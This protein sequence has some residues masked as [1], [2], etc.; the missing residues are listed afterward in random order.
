MVDNEDV[1]SWVCDSLAVQPNKILLYIILE[2]SLS[3]FVS[4]SNQDHIPVA[5]S[6]PYEPL[7]AN[8]G[9]D[10]G[11]DREED[12]HLNSNWDNESPMD[13]VEI[14]TE[15]P[16]NVESAPSS[17]YRSK[18]RHVEDYENV[19]IVDTNQGSKNRSR[20]PPRRSAMAARPDF[21]QIVWSGRLSDFRLITRAGR[22]LLGLG[23][24]YLGWAGG[25]AGGMG[26]SQLEIVFDIVHVHER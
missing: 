19:A 12:E 15:Q 10:N 8:S 2:C 16:T 14:E 24:D 21:K 7:V 3:R 23:G 4:E 6:S 11:D 13:D 18:R 5:L 20:R 22:R 17:S 26:F 9:L 1:A 25:R